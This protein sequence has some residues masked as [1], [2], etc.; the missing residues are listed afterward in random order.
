[1]TW[2]E[3][4][5]ET[6]NVTYQKPTDRVRQTLT[7]THLADV[8]VR[9]NHG[10]YCNHILEKAIPWM[11]VNTTDDVRNI[12]FLITFIFMM[13]TQWLVPALVLCLVLYEVDK[14]ASKTYF[15]PLSLLLQWMDI[16]DKIA[17]QIM[18][19]KLKYDTDMILKLERESMET[20][21]NTYMDEY[22]KFEA[23][24]KKLKATAIGKKSMP[25]PNI[26]QCTQTDQV[27]CND[28][29]TE[30]LSNQESFIAKLSEE[31]STLNIERLEHQ[32]EILTQTSQLRNKKS[33]IVKLEAKLVE[34]NRLLTDTKNQLAKMKKTKSGLEHEISK[35]KI[36]ISDREKA[37]I[38]QTKNMK[39]ETDLVNELQ[40]NIN[41]LQ[42][43]S[44]V[45]IKNNSELEKR[46][47][48][49]IEENSCKICFEQVISQIRILPKQMI[50]S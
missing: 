14:N 31:S 4:Q 21:A 25:S 5:H 32:Q 47:T 50:F 35:S 16:Q 13:Y 37:I 39:M 36:I 12:G 43:E 38:Q 3:W 29:L 48:E 40:R 18:I 44:V 17:D 46:I 2:T 27:H 20:M 6:S 8:L 28:Q 41:I 1:M 34:R 30:K 33:V 7:T 19:D 22:N 24:Y 11:L 15:Q 26:E 42:S 45:R 10:I 23:E 9:T 49:V